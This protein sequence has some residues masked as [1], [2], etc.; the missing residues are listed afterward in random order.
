VRIIT[1]ICKSLRTKKVR[2]GEGGG[3]VRRN[4]KIHMV[5]LVS[6][7]NKD[8]QLHK[9]IRLGQI[10]NCHEGCQCIAHIHFCQTAEFRNC[11]SL[12]FLVHL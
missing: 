11:I 6:K 8:S 7:S 2:E 1:Y 3:G 12:N 5:F 4:L 10:A 9:G